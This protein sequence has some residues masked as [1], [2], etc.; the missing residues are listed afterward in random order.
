MSEDA[1]SPPPYE[2]FVS[3]RGPD[4]RHGFLSHLNVAFTQKNILAFVDDKLQRGDEISASLLGAIERSLMSLVIFSENYAFSRWCLDE[5]VK[6]IDCKRE[7]GQI[8]VPVFYHVDPS[9]VR[10][11]RG[12][13][14]NALAELEEKYNLT[15]A[16]SW[17]SAL[18]EAANLS[19]FHSSNFK[20]D[21]ELIEEII[22]CV[23]KTM[24]DLH[25]V[26]SKVYVGSDSKVL[27][28]ID[29]R[30]AHLILLLD[31]ESEG[32]RLIGIWG[33]GGI[34]KTT[35]AKEAFK[36]LHAKY[37]ASCYL[38]EVSKKVERNEKESLKQE[39][40]STL[41]EEDLK[42]EKTNELP[43]YAKI[44]LG[45]MKV[46]II[47]D[48]V[49][50]VEH[51]QELVGDHKWFGSGSRIIVTTRDRHVLT[52][53]ADDIYEVGELDFDEAHRLFNL[54]AF[55]E[56]HIKMEYNEV[57]KRMVNYAKGI[58][59]VLEVLGGLVRGK[60]IDVWK[61][62]LSK[63]EK[64]LDKKLLNLL[65]L[66][67][68]DLDRE[69]QKNFLDLGY[70][71]SD[72]SV[73]DGL[74][75][76]KDKA[77]ITISEDK[78]I[79]VHDIIREMA[80]EIV[81]QESIEEPENRS[82]L[83]D[84]K[85]IR[86]VLEKD[87]GSKSIRGITVHMS[88][89]KKL[90]LSPDVFAKMSN[91]K[92]LD[93][94][95]EDYS[96]R[97]DLPQGLQPFPTELRYLRWMTYPLKFLPEKFS[98]EN[99]VLFDLSYSRVEKLW[100]G[101]QDLVNLKDVKLHASIF[102]KEL[103]DFSKATNLEVLD[104][105]DCGWLT[106]VHPS[107]FTLEKLEK[108]YLSGCTSLTKLTIHTHLSSLQYLTLRGCHMLKEFSVTSE[109]MIELD[110]GFT[111]INALPSSIGHQSKLEILRLAETCIESLPATIKNLTRLQYLDIM[112]C[113]DLRALPELPSSI[114]KLY[115]SHCSSLKT[116]LFPL[117]LAA[118]LKEN[119]KIVEFWNC[120]KLDKHSRKA[121]GLNA[122]INMMKFAHQRHLSAL[123]GNHVEDYEDYD[124]K[125]KYVYPGSSVPEWL[126]YRTTK[127]YVAIN[128]SSASHSPL[129][130]FIFCFIIPKDTSRAFRVKLMITISDDER[131]EDEGFNIK[132]DVFRPLV[133][134][135]SD[136][137]FI[138]Y[139]ERCSRYLN[140]RA[141]NQT[142]FKILVKAVLPY[143]ETKK[144]L[145]S[146]DV[147]VVLKG[148]GVS[149]INASAYFK[150]IQQ[151]EFPVYTLNTL[152]SFNKWSWAA[153]IATTLCI[154][155]LW[156]KI[157][158]LIKKLQ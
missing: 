33:M 28:G 67:Y 84:P 45:R 99:L 97:V 103:P 96:D 106:S 9:D 6:I 1:S 49:R 37:H 135:A 40:Y 59:L 124:A 4:V 100:L 112:Y 66:S 91:L 5:L 20:N 152:L 52:N 22:K 7:N 75:R 87:K 146:Y 51:L 118:Q 82:R 17:R 62:K 14:G 144:R 129:L 117:T 131:G 31:L 8:V 54:N 95:S 134:V 150:F 43:K 147:L 90:N 128:I 110:L 80:W 127:D 35:I 149:P 53:E 143:K 121:I 79:S 68:D 89:I 27:V 122:Q 140:S 133:G 19:G 21:A 3:F 70:Y 83:W 29:K 63:L 15:K 155:F 25:Q 69:E 137:V 92:F 116:I 46:L 105:R 113:K 78:V 158:D 86:K 32:V 94:H 26:N 120:L 145:G 50:Q 60:D 111:A 42:I 153:V 38:E 76:L 93:F 11:Q 2:V 65:R 157:K 98:A 30:I 61:S 55:K 41:L 115:A 138:A 132:F 73:L 23:L 136:H 107:I 101:V 77:L 39:L 48:D 34:G 44:R 13:Y 10:N 156:F 57:S 71:E 56:N 88:A 130:G 123:E 141:Q 104:L 36:R 85:D 154:P 126:E 74:E 125:V 16:Q 114:E 18:A 109:N 24:N 108:L 12:S 119:R 64:I 102:L 139:D 81:R 148:F 58:P 72:D 142:R 47:L 151:M